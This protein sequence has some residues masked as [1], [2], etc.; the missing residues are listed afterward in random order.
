[1]KPHGLA[2]T[3]APTERTYQT[4]VRVFPYTVEFACVLVGSNEPIELNQELLKQRAQEQFSVSHF[5]QADI[6]SVSCLYEIAKYARRRVSLVRRD[7]Y[8][9]LVS[10]RISSLFLEMNWAH[11]N[12]NI[13]L[14]A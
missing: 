6:D 1:M 12:L 3:W 8:R 9:A 13:F 4:F 2:V 11:L 7:R 5:G 10:I 14:T